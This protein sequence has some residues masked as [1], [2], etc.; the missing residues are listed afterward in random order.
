MLGFC[1]DCRQYGKTV[2]G[3]CEECLIKE[4]MGV[5][6]YVKCDICGNDRG[7]PFAYVCS[8]CYKKIRCDPFI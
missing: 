2:E 1:E 4:E 3:L 8:E 7:A 6:P 5:D